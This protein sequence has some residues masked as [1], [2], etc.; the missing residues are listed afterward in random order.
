MPEALVA[1][2]PETQVAE[3]KQGCPVPMYEW[4]RCGRPI[5]AAPAGVDKEP[6]CL[7][8]S[9]DPNKDDAAFQ[10]EFERILRDAGE[11]VADFSRF[12]FPTANFSGRKF[13]P[14]CMFVETT[15]PQNAYFFEA[16]FMRDSMFNKAMF[17]QG[18]FFEWVRFTHDAY[19]PE[20]TFAQEANFI[21]ARFAHGAIF[22]KATFSQAAGFAGAK[23]VQRASFHKARFAHGA[24]FFGAT[25]EQLAAFN[26]GMFGS[27]AEFSHA[28]FFD[29]AFFIGTKFKGH[30]R[31]EAATFTQ[32]AHLSGATFAQDANFTGATFRQTADFSEATFKE[33]VIFR[34]TVFRGDASA[35]P[36][37]VFSLARFEEPELVLFYKTYLGQALFH[38]CDVSQ[39]VFSTV[40]WRQRPNGKRMVLEEARDLDLSQEFTSALRTEEGNPDERNYGLIA[41]L[42]QQLKK[43]YDDR[44]DYWTAGDFHYG[45]MEMKRLHSPRRKKVLRWLHR[46]FGLVALY[47]YVSEYGESYVRPALLLVALF[48]ACMLLYPRL[49]LRPAAKSSAPESAASESRPVAKASPPELSYANYRRYHSM[50]LGG[51]RVTFWSLLGHSAM[52][53][54][55][56]AAFQRDLAYEPSY[57]WGRLLAI[58]EIVLTSTLL[59]LF[60]LA[61]RRQFRR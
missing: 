48:M 30:A 16:T 40:R 7:M 8:H 51:P 6:V 53:T 42:Y 29:H 52:T 54:I 14:A 19:F 37:P 23:F 24:N 56:V 9:H 50:D 18:A 22:Q 35:E 49:G 61:V 21:G 41:E 26:Q 55:G 15:F 36:G 33:R 11:G 25:F 32:G 46:N 12:V 10:A 58:V 57:P 60:L 3:A 27:G 45:E 20:A 43:N 39:F 13:Q 4:R 38:N 17:T 2:Q 34:E 5:Y 47:G 59:A 44:K 28:I 1:E 31:F